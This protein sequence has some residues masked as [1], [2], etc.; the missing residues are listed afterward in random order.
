MVESRPRIAFTRY[1]KSAPA[2]PCFIIHENTSHSREAT[3]S[4]SVLCAGGLRSSFDEALTRLA[5][6]DV[7][8]KGLGLAIGFE[9]GPMTVMVSQAPWG[10]RATVYAITSISLGLTTA[11][12][13]LAVVGFT[14]AC[15][16]SER[17][18]NPS[19]T[20]QVQRK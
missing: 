20:I 13:N 17:S 9:F 19:G 3:I 14:Q 11:K 16:G 18:R 5:D 2:S 1:S 10:R 15:D 6:Q 8:A 12:K 4:N 7:D